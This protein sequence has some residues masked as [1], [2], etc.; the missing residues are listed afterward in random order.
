MFRTVRSASALVTVAL[1]AIPA[2]T[3]VAA[4]DDGCEAQ[5][6]SELIRTEL[7][8]QGDHYTWQVTASSEANCIVVKF[9]LDLKMQ[10]PDGEDVSD[11][12]FGEVKVSNGSEIDQMRYQMKPAYQ[13]VDWSVKMTGCDDCVLEHPD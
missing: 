13:L 8:P 2:A 5:I 9:E 7:D 3:W 1:L 6:S 12:Q 11:S 10:S 4:Q